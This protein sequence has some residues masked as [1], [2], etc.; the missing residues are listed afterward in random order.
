[1]GWLWSRLPLTAINYIIEVE[2]KIA[3]STTHLHGDGLALWITSERAQP[4]PVF[5]SKDHFTGIGI[6]LDTYKNDLESDYPFP[7]IVAMQGDGKTSY[8]VG[9]DGVP[10]MIGEC[11]ADYRRTNIGTK[12]KVIYVKDKVL[13]V[14]IQWRGWEEWSDCFTLKD[15]SV[16]TNPFIGLTAMTGDVTDAH[17]IISV[18]IS[19]A[20]L[21]AA[22]APRDKLKTSESGAGWFSSFTRLL[23]FGAAIAGAWYG[24]KNYGSRYFGVDA[25]SD[26]FGRGGGGLMW[27][28]SKRF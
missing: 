5:G 4:G 27:A 11:T 19:S 10:T 13:D 2:F 16:P 21:S 24:W 22:E 26:P 9:K 15:I 8:D 14:K 28:D 25:N 6:F 3:G 23:L 7:R 1:M 20:I 12:L 18:S 17:D